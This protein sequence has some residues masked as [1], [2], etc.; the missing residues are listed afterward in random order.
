MTSDHARKA[1]IRRQMAET[2]KTYS[3]I[4]QLMRHVNA[5]RWRSAEMPWAE[6][7][8]QPTAFD[9]YD[10]AEAAEFDRLMAR[11]H[12]IESDGLRPSRPALERGQ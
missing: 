12:V 9:Q 2:G 5:T 3:Q 8:E 10:K 4:D 6:P 11:R 7:P 1:E